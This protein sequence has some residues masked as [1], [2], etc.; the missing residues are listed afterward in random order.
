MGSQLLSSERDSPHFSAD[1][2]CGQTAGWI[3]MLLGMEVGLGPGDTVLD[4]D[5]A[6]PKRAHPPILGSCLL[7]PNSWMGQDANWYEDRPRPIVL[8]GYPA[9]LKRAKPPIFGPSLLWSNGCL[10]QD[11]TWYGGRPQPRR[12][13]VGWGPSSPTPQEEQP[14]FSANL[15][16]CQTAGWTTTPLGMEV[17]VGP[18]D[19]VFDGDPGPPWKGHSAH[20][21][22]VQC[23]LWPNGWM[24]QDATWYGGRTWPRQHCVRWGPKRLLVSGYHLVR[25]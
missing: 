12:H 14:Q 7:W 5:P 10:Y 19:F 20:P 13:C 6:P 8:D 24:D 1:L 11:T 3:K 21:I 25:W 23:L 9:L 15:R 22:F 16:C 18:G 4:G 2:Y 17:D